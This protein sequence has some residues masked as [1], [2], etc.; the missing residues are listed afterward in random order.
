MGDAIN[1]KTAANAF[2]TGH[3]WDWPYVLRDVAKQLE[4]YAWLAEGARNQGQQVVNLA[5]GSLLSTVGAIGQEP[6]GL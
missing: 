1:H 6:L 2:L 5:D 4:A 3:G